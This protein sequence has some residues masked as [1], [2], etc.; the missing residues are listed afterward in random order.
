MGALNVSY[1]FLVPPQKPTARMAIN[2][3]VC[4]INQGLM[5]LVTWKV[6]GAVDSL[7]LMHIALPKG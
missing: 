3:L 5:F 6:S 2:Y 7:F 4:Q 1:M